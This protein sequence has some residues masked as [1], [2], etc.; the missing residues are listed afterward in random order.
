[1]EVNRVLDVTMSEMDAFVS[2]SVLQDIEEA[3]S[4]TVDVKNIRPGYSYSKKLTGRNGVDGRVKATIRELTSGKYHI[5][6]KSNQGVNHLSYMY[7]PTDDGKISLTYMEDYEAPSTS[8]KL[9]YGLMSFLYNHSS[10]K[11]IN[12]ILSNIERWIHENR[13]Q[14]ED[15]EIRE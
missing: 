3:T 4:K 12:K 15:G 8:K 7:E 2:K 13:N 6:F 11:R 10:K 5:T 14:N 9:N 1:M